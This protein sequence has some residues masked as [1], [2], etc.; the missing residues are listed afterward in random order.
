MVVVLVVFI[1]LM[2]C[3]GVL[4]VVLVVVGC[5]FFSLVCICL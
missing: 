2:D 5:V 4:V 1:G 3:V